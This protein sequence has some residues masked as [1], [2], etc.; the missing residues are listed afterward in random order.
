MKQSIDDFQYGHIV[1]EFYQKSLETVQV[2][3]NIKNVDTFD[4]WIA[5]HTELHLLIN[6]AS[7]DYSQGEQLYYGRKLMEEYTRYV[8]ECSRQ[9]VIPTPFPNI[10]IMNRMCASI[11]LENGRIIKNPNYI[12]DYKAP[13][14]FCC[15]S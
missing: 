4:N 15:F 14:W 6:H 5:S 8:S 3:K 1:E 10:E 2:D 12:S 7:D 11:T 13:M 9:L